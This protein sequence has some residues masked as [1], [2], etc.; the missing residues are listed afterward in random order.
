MLAVRRGRL[1]GGDGCAETTQLG[2]SAATL[3]AYFCKRLA[4]MDGASLPQS[5]GEGR[6]VRVPLLVSGLGAFRAR[7]PNLN[8]LRMAFT[9]VQRRVGYQA[10]W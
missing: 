4:R 10:V 3:P 8:S 2:V 9:P 1:S 6:L 5:L 7:T